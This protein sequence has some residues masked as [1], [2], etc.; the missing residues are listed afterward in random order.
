M[1]NETRRTLTNAIVS[2][3][4][5]WA[6]RTGL[7]V[8]FQGYT[9]RVEDNLFKFC[10]A[11]RTD[12]SGGSGGELG[13]EGKRGKMLA[14][15]SSS[16]LA[17]NF[18]N[19]WREQDRD[20]LATALDLQAAITSLRFEQQF[21]TPL[22]G[23]PPNLDVVLCLADGRTIAIESKFL[24]PY[25]G[26]SK[27]GGFSQSYF[28]KP[29]WNDVNLPNCQKLVNQV[30]AGEITFEILDVVQLLKHALGLAHSV[31]ASWQLWYLWFDA[32]DSVSDAHRI[33]L[34]QF[35]E[36]VGSELRFFALTYQT[37]LRRIASQLDTCSEYV[38]YLR[39]RYG[40]A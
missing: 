39:Q 34:L 9:V 19:Y 40:V 31:K 5:A 27:K 15:H 26:P 4:Q 22:W 17:C 21:R 12:F 25:S 1:T 37:L 11:A 29:Y 3:Q 35:S 32:A 24:E 28:R 16:A 2:A 10:D 6:R 8:D 33:E 14:L 18:F 7:Q 38:D 13:S 36:L 30:N 23:T 20:V